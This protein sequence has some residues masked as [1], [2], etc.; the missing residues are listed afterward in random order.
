MH[1]EEVLTFDIDNFA[2]G[3]IELI[4]GVGGLDFGVVVLAGLATMKRSFLLRTIR[5]S[6]WEFAANRAILL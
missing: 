1:V 2:T 5:L 4:D 6:S 3:T